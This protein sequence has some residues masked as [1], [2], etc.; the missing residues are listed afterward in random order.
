MKDNERRLSKLEK[1]TRPTGKPVFLGEAGRYAIVGK[2]RLG[3]EL[4]Q[5]R[6]PRYI[7]INPNDADT[8]GPPRPV[9]DGRETI[10]K[11]PEKR[12]SDQKR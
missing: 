4:F 7:M 3:W 8:N 6:Y 9:D 5:S 1:Q 12:K 11:I 10:R 2:Y